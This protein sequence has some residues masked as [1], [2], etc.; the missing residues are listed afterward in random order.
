MQWTNNFRRRNFSKL[1]TNSNRLTMQH[2]DKLKVKFYVL[3]G[4]E[5][6]DRKKERERGERGRERER[7]GER[8]RE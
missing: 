6:E 1:N 4:R 7:T 5:I 8:G 2:P 3:P